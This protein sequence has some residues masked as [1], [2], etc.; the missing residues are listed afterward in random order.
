[1]LIEELQKKKIAILGLGVEGMAMA[2]YFL[3]HE[4]AFTI[5]DE[6]SEDAFT[7]PQEKALLAKITSKQLIGQPITVDMLK[8]FDVIIRSPGINPKAVV[9]QQAKKAGVSIT[10]VTNIFFANCPAKIIGVTGTKGKG[11]TS[12]LIYEMLKKA[13]KDAYLGGNIGRPPVEFLDN[14][15]TQSIVVLELSSYQLQDIEKS[16]NIAV[17]LMVTQEHLAPDREGSLQNYHAD[18]ADYVDAKRNL[19][20]FQT[21]DDMAILNSDYLATVDS[22][23]VAKGEVAF[24]SRFQPVTNGCFVQD[25]EIILRWNGKEERVISIFDILLPGSHNHENICAAVMAAYAAGVS[26]DDIRFVLQTFKGLEHRLELV[27]ELDGVRYYDDSFSTVPET[28]IAAIQAFTVPEILL[29]GGSTKHSNF[30]ELGKVLSE[31]TNVK[32]VIVIGIEWKEIQK[33]ITNPK[34]EIIAGLE[35]M[36]AF[37]QK[38]AAI[39]EKGDVVLLS[40]ACA[41][42]DKF[43]NYKDRGNQFKD[44][45]NLL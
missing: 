40:P 24:V 27:R 42:F 19:I 2:E 31:A 5:V 32:A 35:N 36:H 11:T 12:S 1:M 15:T 39:A 7:T 17:M 3:G 14:L 33:H 10:S 25:N 20:R 41:S 8:S 38:A 9:L 34:F 18:I 26:F 43:K 23:K 13:Q 37:V 44:T 22:Q 6:R 21:A 28:A 16:P 30:A 45:V 29:L 4:I